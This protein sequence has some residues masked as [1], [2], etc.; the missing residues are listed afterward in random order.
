MLRYAEG[1]AG[2][3]R[4]IIINLLGNAIKFTQE[5]VDFFA[6]PNLSKGGAHLA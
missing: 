6:G 2:K 4:Q 5:G 3:L 1:D